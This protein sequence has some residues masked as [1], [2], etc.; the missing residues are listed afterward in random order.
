MINLFLTLIMTLI[1]SI[2][3]C[4]QDEFPEFG[5]EGEVTLEFLD[6]PKDEAL[7]NIAKRCIHEGQELEYKVSFYCI[8]MTDHE[9]V[10]K[11]SI[12]ADCYENIYGDSEYDGYYLLDGKLIVI[13]NKGSYKLP[14][15]VPSKSKTFK[16][17][18]PYPCHYDP[19]EWFCCIAS[20]LFGLH[21]DYVGWVWYEPD[22]MTVSSKDNTIIV[23]M[24]KRVSK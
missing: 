24:P 1:S 7:Y 10:T 6:L 8:Y 19:K 17:F 21:V 15:T 3:T 9:G 5:K 18:I 20:G 16:T 11:V 4:Q 12:S 22:D 2:S 13:E 23:T 14:P